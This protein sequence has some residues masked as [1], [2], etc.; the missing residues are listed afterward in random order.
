MRNNLPPGSS[1]FHTILV[2]AVS[3]TVFAFTIET[4]SG[5][6]E[7]REKEKEESIELKKARQ[8]IAELETL[9]QAKQLTGYFRR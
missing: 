7:R 3:A 9:V 5:W 4:Y 8:R 1:I 6:R 2:S